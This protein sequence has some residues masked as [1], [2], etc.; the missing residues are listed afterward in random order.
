MSF[1]DEFFS[2]RRRL[3]GLPEWLRTAFSGL[4]LGLIFVLM[5]RDFATLRDELASLGTRDAYEKPFT[6]SSL[7][8]YAVLI[9][10]SLHCIS[11]IV[12]SGRLVR[13]LIRL[14][15]AVHFLILGNATIL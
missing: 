5:E 12:N 11:L 1:E 13:I 9:I 6:L 15:W 3:Y 4:V 2:I 14:N 8:S 10:F 7:I